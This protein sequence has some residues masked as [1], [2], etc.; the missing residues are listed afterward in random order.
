[1]G[2]ANLLDRAIAVV[3]P[4]TAARRV[5]A[6]RAFD[7]MS[8][9]YDGANRDRLRNSWRSHNTSADTEIAAAGSLLRDR[10]RD[11]VR[12]NPYAANALAVLVTHAVGAGIVPRSKDKKVNK[13]F[14]DWM[15]QCD[16]DGHLD[17]HGIISLATREMLESGTGMVRRRRRLAEDGLAVPLQLQVLEVDHLDAT[18]HGELATG[19]R[20]SYGI[21]YNGIGKTTA[22]WL[23]P[24]HPG[25]TA[26][27]STTSLSSVS[28]PAEDIVFGFKKLRAGQS[29][30]VPWGHA[31]VTSV[32]DLAGYEQ[33]E[34]VRKRLES[35]MV[36]VVTGGD[37]E[38]GVGLP[39]G[40]DDVPGVYN[41]DG[42]IV[43]KFA[44]G[45][46]YHARGGKDIKFTQP[47]NTANYDSYKT[48]MLHTIAVGFHV[49]HAFLSG[50]LDKVNYS[51]SKIG[52]E[53]YKKIIDDLQ[54]QVIIPMICQPLWD[55][56]C[57]AAFW[58]GKIKT[59]KVAVEWS[60]PRFP[61]ADEAKDVAARVAAV[62]SGLLNP[63]VAIAET[64]FTPEE[65]IAGFVEW[66]ALLDDNKLIFDS[67]PRRMS[68]A[69]QTQQ[70]ADADKADASNEDTS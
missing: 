29:Q 17:F 46:L 7:V 15:K 63:L 45:M 25:S 38:G 61:S 12:N 51:S 23:F 3:A 28:V 43:E 49:P 50:R 19:R 36:G 66:N 48:S 39:M 13:L 26:I 62:R 41:A 37:D 44:P 55:W 30:G 40:D 56:F 20:A 57:E 21:E 27:T 59:R 65:V 69:G 58:A 16:A 4:R 53:T 31:A 47:A 35:C 14:A 52:L 33:S 10:M 9:G 18:R 64:G 60:P 68:Q 32:Y 8:R 54:W 24:N 67:D 1:M 22:Y 70:D 5:A 2:S 11:L 6:R 34:L 42:E